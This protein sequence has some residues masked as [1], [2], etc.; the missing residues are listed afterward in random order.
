MRLLSGFNEKRFVANWATNR[1]SPSSPPPSLSLSGASKYRVPDPQAA[2]LL[3]YLYSAIRGIDAILKRCPKRATSRHDP[4]KFNSDFMTR[5]L[6]KCAMHVAECMTSI[7]NCGSDARLI[8]SCC[9][10]LAVGFTLGRFSSALKMSKY[11]AAA[12]TADGGDDDVLHR[13]ITRFAFCFFQVRC[14]S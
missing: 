12:A 1:I 11:R 6:R 4:V 3:R 2:N 9:S 13:C 7:L 5:G 14:A 10:R 8:G